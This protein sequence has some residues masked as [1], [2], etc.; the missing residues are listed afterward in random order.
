[1]GTV[2][3][4]TEQSQ[5]AGLNQN[6]YSYIHTHAPMDRR[7]DTHTCTHGQTDKLVALVQAI[8]SQFHNHI[9]SCLQLPKLNM[10]DCLHR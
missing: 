1:M 10:L 8:F 9:L 3:S 2:V 5:V 7:T 4:C 6:A